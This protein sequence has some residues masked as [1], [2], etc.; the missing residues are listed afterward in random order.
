MAL[1]LAA[2]WLSRNNVLS[3]TGE[4][5]FRYADNVSLRFRFTSPEVMDK[6]DISLLALLWLVKDYDSTDARDK[7][8]ATLG[9]MFN[10]DVGREIPQ[11]LKPDY[12]KTTKQVYQ[13][14]AKHTSQSR[15]PLHGAAASSIILGARESLRRC[16]GSSSL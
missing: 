7:V 15:C 4:E 14:V 2:A 13:D 8:F 3:Q 11:L 1:G 9:L 10:G 16:Q 5:G 6:L 12:S